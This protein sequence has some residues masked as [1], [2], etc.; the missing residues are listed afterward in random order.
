MKKLGAQHCQRKSPPS[1]R[2]HL[3]ESLMRYKQ[4]YWPYFELWHTLL[5]SAVNENNL[6]FFKNEKHFTWFCDM[7]GED[8]ETIFNMLPKKLKESLGN[9]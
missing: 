5:Y 8:R 9:D 1:L 4:E 2:K 7:M 3:N 6:N